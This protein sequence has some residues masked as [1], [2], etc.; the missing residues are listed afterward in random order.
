[1]ECPSCGA[2]NPDG[3]RFCGQCGAALPFR[4]PACGSENPAETK[5]C[6][7]CGASLALR[8]SGASVDRSV[9]ALRPTET[10]AGRR[11]L[12]VMFCDLVGST[13]LAAEL[14]PEDLAEVIRRFQSTC[15]TTLEHWKYCSQSGLDVC[16]GNR[17]DDRERCA[18]K[19][20]RVRL[21]CDRVQLWKTIG[22]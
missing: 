19:E 6:G 2:I 9:E 3:N 8:G 20:C 11:H 5:F 1:M 18:N 13:M 16:N 21:M 14:D 22:G 10:E 7:D 12:T 15:A 17:I 4:C